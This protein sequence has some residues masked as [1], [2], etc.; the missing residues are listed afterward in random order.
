LKVRTP[1]L[2]IGTLLVL[3]A[4]SSACLQASGQGAGRAWPSWLRPCTIAGTAEPARCGVVEV[5]ESAE[6]ASGRTLG[7]HVIVVPA[8]AAIAEADPVLLLAGGPGQ[9][10]GQLARQLAAKVGPIRDRFDLLLI[11]QRGTGQSNGLHCDGPVAAAEL[12]GRIFDMK[13]LAACR[14]ELRKRADL[15]RYTTAASAADYEIIFDALGVRQVHVWGVSYGTR[16]G[17][18][19]ARRFPARVRTLT[20]ESV[21]PV[22]FSW[23]ATGAADLDAALNTVIDD[24]IADAQCSSTYPD[25]RRDVDAAFS[26]LQQRPIAVDVIDPV[27]GAPARV[28][29]SRMDLAYTVRGILYGDGARLPALF[30]DAARANFDGF[31]QVYVNRARTLDQQIANGVLFGVYCAEDVP[32]VDWAAAH[33]AAAGTRIGTYLL[34]QYRRGCEVWPRGTTPAGFR[35]LTRVDVPTLMFSGRHDPVTPPRTAAD[36]A[37]ALP[38]SRRFTWRYGGHGV[39]GTPSAACR[40]RMVEAFMIAADASRVDAGCM[41]R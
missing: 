3:A 13:R 31:G 14:D 16:L 10:A 35:D 15:A 19:I 39:E 11:D 5:R 20:L 28:E 7:I 1:R 32:F 30:R 18:E 34:E 9:G 22:N 17:Y 8:R 21:V 40:N 37:P 25:L 2:S 38:R 24:C 33:R 4:L 23:P 36:A 12:M 27:T 26:R 41:N 29:F 6:P